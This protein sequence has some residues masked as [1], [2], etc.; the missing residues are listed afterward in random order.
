MAAQQI[1]VSAIAGVT[2]TTQRGT[3][4]NLDEKGHPLRPAI[5]WLDQRMTT[6]LKPV[7]GLWGLVFKVIRMT[8]TIAY[9]QAEAE[10][11]WIRV[12]QPDIWAKTHKYLLLSGYLTYRLTGRFVD[13]AGCQ[14]GYIPFD[15]KKLTWASAS[16]WKWQAIPM[17]KALLPELVPPG[18][19][20]GEVT[21]EAADATGLPVG[22]PV[23]AG[24]ADKACEALGAGCIE[25]NI[26][27]LGYGTNATLAILSRRY[28]EII[29]FIPPFPG[30]VPGT[31]SLDSQIHRGYW[32]V[33][34]FKKEFGHL[35]ERLAS[36]QGIEPETLLEKLV[37]QVPPGALGLLLQ[38]YWSPGIK[39]PGREA[40]G[41]VIGFGDA[42]TRA[43]V[44]RAILEGIAYALR[45]GLERTEMRGGV[46]ITELRVCGGGAQ[47]EAGV[48]ISADIFGLP[49]ARPHTVET[50]G[51][52]AAIDAAV[53]LKLHPDFEHAVREMTRVSRVYEPDARAHEIYDALFHRVYKKMYAALQ[54]LYEDICAIT[55][56]PAQ[57]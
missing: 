20:L 18:A 13:S 5:V 39:V 46:K 6:G 29:P 21:A 33:N 37:D 16:D 35:E 22:M 1:P 48:Q 2:L 53:G 38:P 41:A 55:D 44:Y 47:S 9:L 40:K 14:V 23:I 27:C 7:G 57:L 4:V 8:E 49:T 19:V 25:S 54:P 30:A 45:E 28:V 43:H 32:M 42:H 52:G 17:D 12:H 36:E 34:W 56:Y 50:S 51:L 15:Y 3:V 10:A 11:N 26:G 31:Y 24:A